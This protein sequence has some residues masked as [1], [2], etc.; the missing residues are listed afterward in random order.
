MKVA[1]LSVLH[2]GL[3]YHQEIALILICVRDHVEP[4]ATVRPEGL[5]QWKIPV[6][7]PLIFTVIA[8]NIW[9][10]K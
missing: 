3:I 10:L 4:W 1:I 2:T 6:L 5:C 8:R 9:K 7:V